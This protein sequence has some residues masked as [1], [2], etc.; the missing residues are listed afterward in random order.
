MQLPPLVQC[1]SVTSR[2]GSASFGSWNSDQES[3][4]Q[5]SKEFELGNLNDDITV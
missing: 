1:F 3:R 5:P 2:H 4:R